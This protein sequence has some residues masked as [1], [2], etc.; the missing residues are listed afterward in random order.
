M[1]IL[2]YV[3]TLLLSHFAW[4][5]GEYIDLFPKSERDLDR[6]RAPPPVARTARRT[7]SRELSGTAGDIE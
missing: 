7:R 1:R 5:E 4:A 6:E 3:A 2:L